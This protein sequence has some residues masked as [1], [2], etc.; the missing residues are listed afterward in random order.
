MDMMDLNEKILLLAILKKEENETLMDVVLKLENTK[1]FSIKEGK[2]LLKELKKN[3]YISDSF[4]TLKG[5]LVA[6]QVEAEF[7][8]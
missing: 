4:L 2:K 6:K 1:L 3:E 8:I 7:K 5:D